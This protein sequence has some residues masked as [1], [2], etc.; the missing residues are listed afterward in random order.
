MTIDKRNQI[1]D[2]VFVSKYARTINGKKETWEQAVDRV[3]MMH[4]NELMPKITPG[5]EAEFSD[6]WAMVSQAYKEKRILGA[7]RAL[8]Y[9]GSQMLKKN[10]R[11]YNCTS[12]YLN[13]VSF[14][15]ELM[16]ILL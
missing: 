3:M 4:A 13:R 10:M 2:Y 12:S 8:Q 14:F 1:S 7:Q 15:K 6:I 9:G 5:M 16:Y 11:M